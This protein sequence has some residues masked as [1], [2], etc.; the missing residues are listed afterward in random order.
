MSISGALNTA[1]SGILA[2]GDQTRNAAS[3]IANISSVAAPADEVLQPG[4]PVPG[5]NANGETIFR[6]TEIRSTTTGSGG[7]RTQ[8]SLVDPASLPIYAPNA[9]DAN[10]D[11]IS[12]V[13]N[14][15]IVDETVNQIQ[16]QRQLEANVAV[17]RTGDELLEETIDILA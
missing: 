10:A 17:L 12:T 5:T 13:A 4:Q 1:V 9:P 8:T 11:G 15:S 14:V 16:S 3:N 2:A 7:V 6:P